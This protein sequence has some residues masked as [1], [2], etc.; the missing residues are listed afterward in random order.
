MTK[1]TTAGALGLQIA[2]KPKESRDPIELAEPREKIYLRKLWE[3]VE[4]AKKRYV[5]QDF[6]I[7]VI[8]RQE[9][10]IKDCYQDLHSDFPECPTPD[11]DQ[12]VYQ[13]HW[14][15]EKLEL[16]WSLPHEAACRCY[17]NHA[18]EVVDSE[19]ALLRDILDY[20]DG[21]LLKKAMLLNGDT[22]GAP[23]IVLEVREKSELE[24]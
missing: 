22:K 3:H 5:Q 15:D 18:L 13:W 4:D 20:Y 2:S 14:R 12:T 11:Y 6:F 17:Y 8:T 19:K 1:K 7:V 10:L 16:L 9:H 23:Q 24:M 21:T